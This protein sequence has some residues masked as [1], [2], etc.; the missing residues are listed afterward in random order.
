MKVEGETVGFPKEFSIYLPL[1]SETEQ[2]Y[3]LRNGETFSVD[4]SLEKVAELLRNLLSETNQPS[5]NLLF[6]LGS[7][8]FIISDYSGIEQLYDKY[9]SLGVDL[10]KIRVNLEKGLND[11]AIKEATKLREK[12]NLDIIFRLHLLR[13]IA[14]GYLNLGNYE[15][16]RSSLN[17]LFEESIT[18]QKLPAEIKPVVNEILLDG[19]RDHFYVSRYVEE[20]IKLEN[21]LNV[22]LHIATELKNRYQIARF[23]YLLA[24]VQRDSGNI[25]ESHNLTHK[26]LELLLKTGNKALLAAVEGN[27]GTINVILGNYQEATEIFTDILKVFRKLESNRFIALTVKNLGEI[28]LN[29][30]EFEEAIRLYEEAIQILE[31]LNLRETYQ[32]CTLAELYLQTGKLNEFEIIL[33]SI[34]DEIRSNPSPIIE[35]YLISLKGMYDVRKLNYGLAEKNFKT[36]LTIADEQGRGELSAKILMNLILLYLGKFDLEKDPKILDETL[37]TVNYILPYFSENRL[38]KELA[39]MFLLQGK[40]YAVKKEFSKAFNCLQQAREIPI[41]SKNRQLESLINDRIEQLNQVF[42][43]KQT[44]GVDWIIEPFRKEI[45]ILEEVGIR[46]MQ[47]SYVE[48]EVLPLALIILHRSGIP[49]RSYVILK[50][51]VKDQLLFGGFIVAVRDMLSELFEEQKSQMLVITYGNHKIIIEAHPKGFSSVAVSALDSFSLRRKIHQLTDKLASLNIPKQFYGELDTE[52]SKA[53][54]EEV[55]S[56]FGSKL[57]YSDAIK[58]DF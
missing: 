18:S 42:P 39:V 53:I 41:L 36:A 20:K 45:S 8:L 40:I 21:K 15:Q 32:Y 55:K 1:L 28:A 14:Y 54:D 58:V 23:Y 16:C 29:K 46:Y 4:D 5:D 51:A 43:K 50:R 19:H 11:N 25:E 52:V 35:S 10:W 30:G 37:V 56:L 47:K 34:E 22:A 13:S 38:Y 6:V 31:K 12:L 2:E 44:E 26:A 33:K 9:S 48:L 24:L 57:V 3:L 27:L 7:I 17:S 49:L